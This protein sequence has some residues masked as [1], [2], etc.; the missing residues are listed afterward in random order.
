M[1]ST[2]RSRLVVFLFVPLFLVAA[3]FVV[4]S[5]PYTT[6]TRGIYA[7]LVCLL[8]ADLALGLRGR[9]RDAA[10]LIAATV[11]GLAAIE[12]ISAALEDKLR[13]VETKGFSISHP[14]LGWGP[15]G[16]GV[17]HARRTR[18]DGTLIYDVD[19]T[20]DDRLLRRTLSAPTGPSVVFFGDSFTF[21]LG[22]SD[23]DTLPQYYADLTE[24]K[25][26]VLNFAF[27]AYGPQQVLRALETGLF[28]LLLSDAQIFVYLTAGWHIERSSCLAGYTARAPRYE[29]RDGKAVYV[30][31]CVVGLNKVF[32]AIFNGAGYRRLVQPVVNVVRAPDVELYLAELRS[33]AELVKR[34]YHARL[35]ILYLSESDEFLARSG[36]TD[37]MIKERLRQSAIEL[38]DASLSPADFPPGTLFKIPGD[39][40]PTAIANRARAVVLRNYLDE[41]PITSVVLPRAK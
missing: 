32:Q 10:I 24:R 13:I 12:L 41:S 23:S 27:P 26:R 33:T 35:V 36:F 4:A 29:L 11:F 7:F 6:Y 8:I 30:G 5:I 1:S 22:L 9:W 17:F 14:V 25:I 20:I 37:A 2:A 3:A 40:H 38:V 19:Y 28:D 16:P 15:S 34:K 21:G 31:P 18:A 39:S